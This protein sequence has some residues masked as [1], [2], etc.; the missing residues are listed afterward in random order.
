MNTSRQ[1]KQEGVEQNRIAAK[2]VTKAPTLKEGGIKR[3]PR[4]TVPEDEKNREIKGGRKEFQFRT[5]RND[6]GKLPEGATLNYQKADKK[7]KKMN[8]ER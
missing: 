5:R 6:V 1:E 3:K 7:S 4:V 2:V 8:K